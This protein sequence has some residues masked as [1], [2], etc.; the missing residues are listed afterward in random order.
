VGAPVRFVAKN[1]VDKY[2]KAVDLANIYSRAYY[3][4]GEPIISDREFDLLVETIKSYESRLSNK[5]I[6]TDSPT[7]R[8]GFPIECEGKEIPHS[9]GKMLSLDNIND[10]ESLYNWVYPWKDTMVITPKLDGISL[11][12]YYS[13]GLLSH[14]LTRGDGEIGQDVTNL[15]V[16]IGGIPL[17]IDEKADFRIE[18]EAYCFDFEKLRKHYKNHRNYVAGSLGLKNPE[19]F[20]E[21]GIQFVAYNTAGLKFV[22]YTLMLEWLQSISGINN[23]EWLCETDFT[24]D[25]DT[26]KNTFSKKY[27][28][29]DGIVI[30]VNDTNK[31][32]DYT[33]HHP[34]FA[35]AYKFKGE[36]AQTKLVGIEWSVGKLKQVTPVALLEPI[37][38]GGVTISRASLANMANIRTRDIHINDIVN[39]QRAG[40]VIPQVLSVSEKAKDRIIISQKNCPN[41]S[42][43]LRETKGQLFCDNSLC[44]AGKVKEFAHFCKTLNIKGLGIKTLEQLYESKTISNLADLVYM[45]YVELLNGSNIGEKNGLKVI[46]NLHSSY[47]QP[48]YKMW[49]AC[50]IPGLG[51]TMAEVLSSKI[52]TLLNVTKE[53]LISIPRVGDIT[54]SKILNWIDTNYKMLEE[55]EDIYKNIHTV[56]QVEQTLGTIVITGTMDVSRKLIADKLK[57]QGWKIGSA[58]TKNTTYLLFGDK[59]GKK[60]DEA[61][62]KD[63]PIIDYFKEREK[64][65]L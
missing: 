56:K 57:Q 34:K 33:N 50:S 8:V 6:R 64:F 32:T 48:R 17:I 40:D 27:P 28:Y 19:E 30:K 22:S 53:D 24:I 45:D 1:M 51:N 2:N 26:M 7:Q 15:A 35:T 18:G 4:L 65:N 36:V 62:M 12:C 42:E 39:V 21:R 49:A 44:D 47:N 54:A 59:P 10:K 52:T 43:P 60:V 11:A 41:C 29:T 23:I 13:N 58:V 61:R 37:D 63:V 16:F 3:V 46:T 25:V 38:L 20:K 55:L 5:E 9:H 31:W 14:V